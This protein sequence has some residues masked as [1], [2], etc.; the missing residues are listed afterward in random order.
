MRNDVVAALLHN[1][2]AGKYR[3][4]GKTYCAGWRYHAFHVQPRRIK[5]EEVSKAEH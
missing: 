2:A 4:E 5:E 1:Q 3:L